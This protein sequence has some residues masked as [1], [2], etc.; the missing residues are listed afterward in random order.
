MK[1]L[2]LRSEKLSPEAFAVLVR[3]AREE[4]YEVLL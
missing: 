4:G 3:T 1:A 2:N